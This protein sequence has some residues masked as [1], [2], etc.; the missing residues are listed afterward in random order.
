MDALD[1][2]LRDVHPDHSRRILD[3]MAELEQTCRSHVNEVLK[4]VDN[5]RQ[6]LQTMVTRA[7]RRGDVICDR[8]HEAG[9]RHQADAKVLRQEIGQL[10]E[11][12]DMAAAKQQEEA[13]AHSDMV[14]ANLARMEKL[15]QQSLD[16]IEQ[17]EALDQKAQDK[18]ERLAKLEK[19]TE[20]DLRQLRT[21]AFPLQQ[22][23]VIE[24][25]R[26]PNL[27]TSSMPAILREAQ[28]IAKSR[29]PSREAVVEQAVE[30]VEPVE[31]ARGRTPAQVQ[32]LE[33][34]SNAV[35]GCLAA[36]APRSV[37]YQ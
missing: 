2:G 17:H 6:A 1:A 10:K 25:S 18:L 24:R 16:A 36:T 12:I 11:A 5:Q 35:A 20:D 34:L 13:Q 26:A 22:Y 27:R 29:S 15:A 30:P 8:L 21:A 23:R 31:R 4:V 9:E 32:A 7:E 33:E 14:T 3:R 37:V 19:R 28:T